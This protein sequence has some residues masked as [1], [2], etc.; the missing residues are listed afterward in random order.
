MVLKFLRKGFRSAKKRV[1]EQFEII[2]Y[3]IRITHSDKIAR[4]SFV[5]NSFDGSLT[6]FGVILGAL[7]SSN[8][9]VRLIISVG[10][11][12]SIAIGTSGLWGALLSE[13]AERRKEMN[14]LERI[15]LVK[16]DQTEIKKASDFASV[17]VAVVDGLSPFLSAMFVLLPFFLLAY[18]PTVFPLFGIEQPLMFTYYAAFALC[19]LSFFLLG[20]YLGRI[21]KGGILKYGAMMMTAG[22]ISAVLSYLFV[23]A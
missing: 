18:H 13:T 21:S 23:P 9:D 14:E 11:A 19:F 16:L 1:N 2:D 20:A 3:Y 4:R 6:M 15:M 17:M 10:I 5:N 7:I 12:T 22:A 8:D